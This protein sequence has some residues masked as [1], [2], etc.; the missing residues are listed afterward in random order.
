MAKKRHIKINPDKT[1]LNFLTG[2][3]AGVGDFDDEKIRRKEIQREFDI[4]ESMASYEKYGDNQQ[5]KKQKAVDK[6]DDPVWLI[7]SVGLVSSLALGGLVSSLAGL[8]M[9]VATGIS[10]LAVQYMQ[11]RRQAVLNSALGSSG[12]TDERVQAKVKGHS[13]GSLTP[14]VT[15][16]IREEAFVAR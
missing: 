14:D 5:N 1:G 9:L 11:N 8:L 2:G 12:K 16:G 10:I 4:I 3:P 13:L 7:A 6:K 15:P